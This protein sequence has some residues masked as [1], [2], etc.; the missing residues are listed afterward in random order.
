MGFIALS[1]CEPNEWLP[2]ALPDA[3]TGRRCAS[4]PT[5]GYDPAADGLVDVARVLDLIYT[6]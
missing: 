2:Q 5:K 4:P 1:S 3:A 6:Q